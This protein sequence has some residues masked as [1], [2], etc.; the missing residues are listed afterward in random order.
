MH[1]MSWLSWSTLNLVGLAVNFV[2]ALLLVFFTSP[3]L[4]VTK[5]GKGIVGWTNEPTSQEIEK[6][7][8]LYRWHQRGFKGGMLLLCVG[9]LLQLLAE[10]M[11]P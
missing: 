4:M 1:T 10:L 8:R 5:E 6:N 11:R 9:F 7:K 3:A 2:G